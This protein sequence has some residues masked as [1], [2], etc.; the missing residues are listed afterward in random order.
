MLDGFGVVEVVEDLYLVQLRR[1]PALFEI[2]DDLF[3]L[4][5]AHAVLHFDHDP[6]ELGFVNARGWVYHSLVRGQTNESV[7]TRSV[8]EPVCHR[9]RRRARQHPSGPALVVQVVFVP[10]CRVSREQNCRFVVVEVSESLVGHHLVHAQALRAS[11]GEQLL[12]KGQSRV[13]LSRYIY[14]VVDC[15]VEHGGDHSEDVALHFV[16]SGFVTA[17]NLRNAGGLNLLDIWSD[18]GE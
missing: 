9:E 14:E 2:I 15:R 7:R 17:L 8:V 5:G 16:D 3:D 11:S 6:L 10:R 13:S 4:F 18:H 12:S 1:G